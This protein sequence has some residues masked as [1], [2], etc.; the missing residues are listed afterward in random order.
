MT[1]SSRTLVVV[2][3]A[4]ALAAVSAADL[5]IDKTF[6]PEGCDL[7]SKSGD[8]LTMHYTGTL[9]DGTK[10]DSR[11]VVC[12]STSGESLGLRKALCFPLVPF[13]TGRV[14]INIFAHHL[15]SKF[16]LPFTKQKF[17]IR[18]TLT[19]Y[20]TTSAIIRQLTLP[21]TGS[22]YLKVISHF[23]AKNSST[24]QHAFDAI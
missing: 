18:L 6:E 3:L 20:R 2:V 1:S 10:F 17:I 24:L 16:V 13:I 4:T 21:T 8:M 15:H 14:L 19:F 7:K 11:S 9:N 12:C 22:V 23:F 5:V